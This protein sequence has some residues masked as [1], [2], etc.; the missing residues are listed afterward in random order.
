MTK[1][2]RALF[3]LFFYLFGVFYPFSRLYAN[4]AAALPVIAVAIQNLSGFFAGVTTSPIVS[5]GLSAIAMVVLHNP[6]K[7]SDGTYKVDNSVSGVRVPLN[8]VPLDDP[9]DLD[10]W[11]TT[12]PSL[13]VYYSGA[14]GQ[15][16]SSVQAGCQSWATMYNGTLESYDNYGFSAGNCVVK[17]PNGMRSYASSVPFAKCP[18]GYRNAGGFGSAAFSNCILY[19]QRAFIDDKKF[20]VTRDDVY[21]DSYGEEDKYGSL[22][23]KYTT[24]MEYNDTVVIDGVNELGDPLSVY[25]QAISDGRSLVTIKEQKTDSTGQSYVDTRILSF[26]REG[27]L[28]DASRVAKGGSM[29][30]NPTSNS[31]DLSTNNNVLVIN[32]PTTTGTGTGTGVSTSVSFPSDYARSGEASS[33][34]SGIN[35]RLDSIKTA[36]TAPGTAVADPVLPSSQSFSDSYFKNTFTSILGWKLPSHQ[37]SCPS[38]EFDFFN[39]HY[40]MDVHCRIIQSNSSLL[41]GAMTV[42]WSILALF[43]ILGA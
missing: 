33:A 18:D 16:Y 11:P 43:I 19:A 1:R 5:A 20:D 40:I 8:G 24:T 27:G 10:K 28:Y 37:S 3:I 13:G 31:Y 7:N 35:S 15:Q 38:P 12:V 32:N 6:S 17:F 22:V 30:Y 34:A 36:L 4:P 23:P 39:K 26:T 2:F 25:I 14:G 29:T 41:S 9:V 42:V 21:Y